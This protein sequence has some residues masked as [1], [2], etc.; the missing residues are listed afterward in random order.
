MIVFL[1]DIATEISIVHSL[2]GSDKVLYNAA[3]LFCSVLFCSVLFCSVL[4]CPILLWLSVALT[5]VE[6]NILLYVNTLFVLGRISFVVRF[7]F[8]SYC[9][10]S[11]RRLWQLM[12]ESLQFIGIEIDAWQYR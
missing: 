12:E 8:H 9:N 5:F 1:F 7:E 3:V 10:N 2:K 11:I 6:P 4:F